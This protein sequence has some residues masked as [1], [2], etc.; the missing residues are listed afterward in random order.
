M[1]MNRSSV[2][3]TALLLCGCQYDP[4]AHTCTTEEPEPSK[5]VGRYLLQNQTIVGGGAS[6]LRGP[7]CEVNPSADGTFTATDVPPFEFGAWPIPSLDSLV[8][9]SGP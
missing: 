8:S 9:G 1:V 3:A 5:V 4:Y 2:L 6:A 7:L